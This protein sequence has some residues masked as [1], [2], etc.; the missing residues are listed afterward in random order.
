MDIERAIRIDEEF[1]ELLLFPVEF[2][3][4]LMGRPKKQMGHIP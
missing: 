4:S 2:G 3:V 1:A